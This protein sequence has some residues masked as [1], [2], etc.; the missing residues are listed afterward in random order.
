MSK[1]QKWIKIWERGEY[2]LHKM[3]LCQE[4]FISPYAV[5]I[6]GKKIFGAMSLLLPSGGHAHC[7]TEEADYFFNDFIEKV[8]RQTA[9]FR[10]YLQE[11]KKLKKE[12]IFVAKEIG[13]L[14]VQNQNPAKLLALFE[15]FFSIDVRYMLV[16]QYV[17]F[18]LC[19]RAGEIMRGFISQITSDKSA[20]DKFLQTVIAQEK[21]SQTRKQR[22]ELLRIALARSKVKREKLLTKHARRFAWIP[23]INVIE[24]KPLNLSFFK[25]ELAKIRRQGKARE[26]LKKLSAYFKQIQRAYRKLR[27]KYPAGERIL[28]DRAHIL[29]FIRDERDEARRSAYYL[30]TPLYE[31]IAEFLKM[32]AVHLICYTHREIRQALA[33]GTLLA[34]KEIKQRKK[35]YALVLE[36][37]KVAVKTGEHYQKYLKLLSSPALVRDED[38]VGLSAS[39]GVVRG[40]VAVVS[41]FY[42][43]AKVKKGNVL[44]AVTTHPDYL[45]AMRKAAA[46]VT[47]EGGLLSHAAIVSRELKIPCVVGTRVATQVLRDGDKVE[48]DATK[49]IVRKL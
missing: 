8:F 38:I 10:W 14:A 26:E 18:Y 11:Y 25:R 31:A 15:R 12:L 48:V 34:D 16:G 39:P 40:K 44:V 33:K 27:L 29:A 37:G 23:C 21:M 46:I 7:F 43:L 28:I 42:E 3:S 20:Q 17:S 41:S 4:A 49:G 9:R 32:P 30:A 22:E 1:K 13:R 47:D 45:P 35:A 6:L 2:H 36:D 19:G 5:K 24:P